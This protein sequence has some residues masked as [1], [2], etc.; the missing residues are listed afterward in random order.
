MRISQDDG[1]PFHGMTAGR[2]TGWRQA[3]S[4]KTAGYFMEDGRLF[5]GRRRVVSPMSSDAG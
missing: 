3:I 4:W 5:H 1:R 2:F